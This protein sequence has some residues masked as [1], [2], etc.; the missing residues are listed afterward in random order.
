MLGT[1]VNL[2]VV[3]CL[4]TVNSS[5]MCLTTSWSSPMSTRSK[6]SN[7]CLTNRKMQE[8]RTSWAVVAKTKDSDSRAVPAV[9]SVVVRELF[10][11]A[12]IASSV[13]VHNHSIG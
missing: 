6:T 9:A 7:G 2:W 12:T 3:T 4:K 8:P 13:N 5:E 11:K 1:C 10:R